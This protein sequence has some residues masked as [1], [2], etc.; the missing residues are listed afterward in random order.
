M[1][2][3]EFL[4]T[5]PLYRKFRAEIPD[6]LNKVPKPAIHMHCGVCN[7]EQTF[8]MSNDYAEL[9]QYVNVPSCGQVVRACYVCSACD[10][11]Q[12]QFFLKI[13]EKKEYVVKVGQEPSWEIE[14][15]KNLAAM[16]ANHADYYKK[17]LV[18]ESQ[19]YG[20]AAFAYYRRIVEEIIDQLLSEITDLIDES[21]RS[22]YIEALKKT[23]QTRVAQEKIDLVKD[24][25][26]AILRPEGMNPLSALHSALS[27]GLHAQSDEQCMELALHTR[28][29]LIF[30]V[31]QV[32]ASKAASKSFTE[33]MRK[34][35]G[36]KS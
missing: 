2:N 9:F 30:L 32:V 8:N 33:S 24:L 13:G 18:C 19:S 16:L 12:R 22:Q 29:V 23:Q 34:I 1:P 10:R 3:P 31:N 28:Q 26:P 7:S 20:I 27:E 35:L 25:L 11:F 15:D 36:R 5:F 14:V 4:E 17:G 21:E 6:T